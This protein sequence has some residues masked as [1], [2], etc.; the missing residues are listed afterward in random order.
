MDLLNLNFDAVYYIQR[1]RTVRQAYSFAKAM[2]SE[3]WSDEMEQRAGYTSTPEIEV[4]P[5][6]FLS[7][8]NKVY[9]DSVYFEEKLKDRVDR[10]FTYENILQDRLENCIT[11]IKQDMGLAD[12]D[13]IHAKP[14]RKKQSGG[15]DEN[16]L[17]EILAN[18]GLKEHA[19]EGEDTTSAKTRERETP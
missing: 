18:L 7:A 16:Q 6:D 8:L 3:L 12:T 9:N 19:G 13:K 2:N 17:E 5:P 4:K 15:F 11:Q 14:G 10:I 1:N